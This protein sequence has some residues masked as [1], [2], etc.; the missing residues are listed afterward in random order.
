M[1]PLDT[2]RDLPEVP[3]KQR[4]KKCYH[5]QTLP[6]DIVQHLKTSGWDA[7][8]VRLMPSATDGDKALR[9]KALLEGASMGTILLDKDRLKFVELEAKIVGLIGTKESSEQ[10]STSINQSDLEA[11]FPFAKLPPKQAARGA[12]LKSKQA[13]EAL[14]SLKTS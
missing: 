14:N 7:F 9:I 10:T 11:L 4:P 6:A 2:I 5:E 3:E 1:S 13:K 12:A 8:D